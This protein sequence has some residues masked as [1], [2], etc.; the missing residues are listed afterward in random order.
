MCLQAGCCVNPSGSVRFFEYATV[1]KSGLRTQLFFN[2]QRMTPLDHAFT[3]CERSDFELS[4]IPTNGQVD[5][6][7]VFGLT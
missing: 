7:R 1:S 4:D 3:S 2:A 5:N 6:G